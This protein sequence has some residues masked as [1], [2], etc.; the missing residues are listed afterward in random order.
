MSPRRT[1][2]AGAPCCTHTAGVTWLAAQMTVA[3]VMRDVANLREGAF[4]DG[5]ESALEEALLRL[6]MESEGRV[7]AGRADFA[8]AEA[9]AAHA[10]GAPASA[11]RRRRP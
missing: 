5:M 10:R 2:N 3:L 7:S 11:V 4:K 9:V 8:K 1:R 6:V